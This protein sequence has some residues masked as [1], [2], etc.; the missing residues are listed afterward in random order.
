MAG[1]RKAAKHVTLVQSK[2]DAEY[3]PLVQS[4]SGAEYLPFGAKY[5]WCRAAMVQSVQ[6]TGMEQS[7]GS[8]GPTLH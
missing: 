7:R 1:G 4:T 5:L 6:S 2:N 8:G 3:L